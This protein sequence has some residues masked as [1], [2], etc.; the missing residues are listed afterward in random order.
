MSQITKINGV[1]IAIA[2]TSV[3][4][5]TYGNNSLTISSTDNSNYSVTINTMTGLT[6]NGI[7]SA[8][9]YAGLPTDIR[10]TGGTYN[11]GTAT[12]TNNTGGTFTVTGFSTS[13]STEFT[14]GTVTGATNFTGGLTANTFS[15]V[16][17]VLSS[18]NGF[19][20]GGPT[21]AGYV[22][23]TD[24][25]GNGTWQIPATG[26][27]SGTS[28]SRIAGA[29]ATTTSGN[30]TL[31]QISGLTADS[32]HFIEAFVTAKS[33]GT[34]AWAT[35]KRTLSVTTA[36]TT[37]TIRFTNSD[38]D[39]FSNNL[40]ATTVNFAVSG[41]NININVSGVTATDIQWNS[42]YEIITKSTKV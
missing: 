32:T 34:T 21:T 29:V 24:I 35:Y 36:G 6:V 31:S 38:F 5:F 27:S 39:Y 20:M 4:G 40:S 22:L 11:S 15:G 2:N 41:T 42:A 30:T 13:T 16:S 17:I 8:T 3:S 12:F 23:T 28:S 1:P 25:N 18:A 33:S 9:T 7:F 10:V 37:P 14:G 19:K 26:S